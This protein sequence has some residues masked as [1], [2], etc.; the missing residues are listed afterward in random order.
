VVAIQRGYRE[1][2]DEHWRMAYM[3][4]AFTVAGAH[5]KPDSVKSLY[6]E[7]MGIAFPNVAKD[8]RR[9]SDVLKELE[10]QWHEQQKK[11]MTN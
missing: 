10:E 3:I 7:L 9:P 11:S 5:L 2:I 6:K 1:R 4:S 8:D